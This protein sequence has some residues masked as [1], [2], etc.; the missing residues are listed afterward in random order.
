MSLMGK[1]SCHIVETVKR[2]SY[3]FFHHILEIIN[4]WQISIKIFASYF[5]YDILFLKILNLNK[6]TIYIVVI[7]LQ[8]LAMLAFARYHC[9]SIVNVFTIRLRQC[10]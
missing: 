9:D 6:Y 4:S 3:D 8:I 5:L 2:F 1:E 7:T 10:V